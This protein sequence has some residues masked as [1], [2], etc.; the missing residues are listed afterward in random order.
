MT[1][2]RRTS[3][4]VVFS[5]GAARNIIDAP[6]PTS[7]HFKHTGRLPSAQCTSPASEDRNNG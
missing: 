7:S 5:A 1:N 2:F 4:C 6:M 3:R